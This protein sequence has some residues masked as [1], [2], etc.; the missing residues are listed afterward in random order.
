MKLNKQL[1]RIREMM[2]LIC[3]LENISAASTGV[4]DNKLNQEFKNYLT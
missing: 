4:P 2:P 3:E 1:T